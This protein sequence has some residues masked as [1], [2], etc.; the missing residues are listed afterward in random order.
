MT[1]SKNCLPKILSKQ[2]KYWSLYFLYTK[3]ERKIEK[4]QKKIVKNDTFP[5][6]TIL[7]EKDVALPRNLKFLKQK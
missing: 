5:C 2:Q 4:K 3:I 6:T 1:T 7:F